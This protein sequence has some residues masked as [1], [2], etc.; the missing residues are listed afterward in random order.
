MSIRP[1]CT[2]SWVQRTV[3]G[4]DDDGN[5]VYT[6]TVVSRDAVFAPGGSSEQVQGGDLVT[7]VPTVYLPLPAPA[8]VDRMT[9]N[10]VTYDVDGVPQ[11]WGPSPFSTWQPDYPVVVRLKGVTG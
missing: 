3:T 8:V 5:D 11:V 10:G 6:D 1:N 9:V 2:A 4:L 7:T